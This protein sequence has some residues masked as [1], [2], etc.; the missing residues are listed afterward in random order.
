MKSPPRKC[1][2]LPFCFVLFA[3]FLTETRA[4]SPTIQTAAQNVCR[5]VCRAPDGSLQIGSGTYLRDEV[6]G[7]WVLTACH[8]VETQ[9]AKQGR[10]SCEFR[11][12]ET[13]EGWVAGFD[14][15]YDQ[16]AIR[17]DRKPDLP[18]CT[19]CTTSLQS[20]E[21]IWFV[22]Y[23]HG[24][25]FSFRNGRYGGRG[26][27]VKPNAAADWCDASVGVVNG[28]SGGPAFDENGHIA[29]NLWGS[30]G[31][32]T[33]FC[34]VNRNTHFL[35]KL[36][37]KLL[38]GRHGN[39][40]QIAGNA[41]P[42]CQND[43]CYGCCP[44]PRRPAVPKV[45]ANPGPL[46]TPGKPNPLS[47]I[48]QPSPAIVDLTPIIDRIDQLESALSQLNSCKCP[49]PDAEQFDALIARLDQLDNRQSALA[50]QQNEL[51][52]RQNELESRQQ[53]LSQTT[54]NLVDA[55]NKLLAELDRRTDPNTLAQ[56]LPGINVV[57]NGTNK[58][59]VKLGESLR[60]N[61]VPKQ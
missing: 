16:A 59:A 21:S 2:I 4:Q 60:L 34:C 42:P 26:R 6:A 33:T 40:Q 12:G 45:P 38:N 32:N 52:N 9:T 31:S 7:D 49:C 28:M 20:Q 55:S 25:E 35:R 48:E 54:L 10:V 44:L 58:G 47:P 57:H 3:C 17:L 23:A 15:T 22:G 13:I 50:S 43:V 39:D 41:K 37:P 11:N 19:I 5:V 36:F 46:T 14:R 27:P 30:D 56:S 53:A 51:T 29:G 8:V 18:G 1:L 61:F 24:R